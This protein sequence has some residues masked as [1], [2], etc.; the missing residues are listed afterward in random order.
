MLD[1]AY[2]SA[3]GQQKRDSIALEVH[4]ETEDAAKQAGLN[5]ER[6]RQF[7]RSWALLVA[8]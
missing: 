2:A 1:R 6:Q 8:V 5:S 7:R 4:Y 3:V